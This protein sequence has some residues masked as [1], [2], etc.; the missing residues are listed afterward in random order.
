MY[1]FFNWACNQK[2]LYILKSCC[3]LLLQKQ[4]L[5]FGLV[6]GWPA[7]LEIS[8]IWL[9]YP[10]FGGVTLVLTFSWTKILQNYCNII[11]LG[12]TFLVKM[13]LTYH[14]SSYNCRGNYST[15]A[16]TTSKKGNSSFGSA[17]IKAKIFLWNWLVILVS[18]NSLTNFAFCKKQFCWY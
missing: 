9:K 10:T 4:N 2:S 1:W 18:C 7:V 5:R 13:F 15:V 17:Q 12:C 6:L 8:A 16:E 14:I 11:A 3:E